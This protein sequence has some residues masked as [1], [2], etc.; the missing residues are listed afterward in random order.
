MFSQSKAYRSIFGETS[1]LAETS[2]KSLIYGGCCKFDEVILQ[3]FSDLSERCGCQE[4][5][6][7]GLVRPFSQHFSQV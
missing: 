3:K 7:A 4:R 2:D 5:S 6:W 1:R